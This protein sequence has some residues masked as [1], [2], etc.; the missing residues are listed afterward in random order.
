M[1]DIKM[2]S[3]AQA[4]DAAYIYA[5]AANGSQVKIKKSDLVEVIRATM[6]IATRDSKGL[7]PTN[8]L[9]YVG[10]LRSNNLEDV[11]TSFGYAYGD[12]DGSGVSGPF[13][14]LFTDSSLQIKASFSGGQLKFRVFNLQTEAWSP[15]RSITII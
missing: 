3:F 11:G 4:T 6:P 2:N 9:F 15:W 12:G 8:G 14:S 7:M 5:E 1:E 10:N 13:L